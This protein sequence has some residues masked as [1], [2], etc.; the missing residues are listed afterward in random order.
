[1]DRHDRRPLI[2]DQP[3]GNLDSA[4]IYSSLVPYLRRAKKDRQIILVTHNP[5]LVI[6]ADADQ[7]IVA[8]ARK[9]AGE[10]H[11]VITYKA[12]SLEDC[13]GDASIRESACRLLEGG[14][15][16]FRT[17]EDRYSI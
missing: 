7:V 13:E 15:E 2:I 9:L 3:E 5:N 14:R 1:M 10:P 12:G 16:A 11:P 17:R 4:S 8:S 6:A